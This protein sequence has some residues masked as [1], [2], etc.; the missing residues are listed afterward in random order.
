MRTFP[1]LG[2]Q[3]L[4]NLWRGTD[5][6][7][8]VVA[9]LLLMGIGYSL[10]RVLAGVIT[11][12]ALD[13]VEL[14]LSQDLLP[15]LQK[16]L[17]YEDL[18]VPMTGARLESFEQYV[19]ANIL[20][21]RTVRINI[22]STSGQVIY[23]DDHDLIGRTFD[24]ED[25]LREAI[26]GQVAK[27]LTPAE[28]QE[29][30]AEAGL[31]SMLEVY[32]PIVFEPPRVAGVFEVYEDYGPT[33]A[34]VARI[35]R[36][37]SVGLGLALAVSY[38]I[39]MPI[40]QRSM[41]VVRR[42]RDKMA[43]QATQLQEAY[44]ALATNEERFRSLVVN[45]SDVIMIVDPAGLVRYAS[46]SIRGT[47]GYEPGQ[48]EGRRLQALVRD[49]EGHGL[50]SILQ[51]AADDEGNCR[52]EEL[53][54]RRA[55]GEWCNVEA[56]V[57]SLLHNES[58]GGIVVNCRDVTERKRFELQL[59]EMAYHDGLTGLPNRVLFL[60]RLAASIS[61]RREGDI[62][63]VMIID[64]DHFKAVN[65]AL[66][67]AVGDELLVAVAR[68]IESVVPGCAARFGGDEFAV[69]LDGVVSPD[70]AA[71]TARRLLDGMREP[72][73]L[74]GHETF[75]T[76][77]IGV[78]VAVEDVEPHV[79]IRRADV[80][81]YHCKRMG[82]A[83]YA[84]ANADL[85]EAWM[86]RLSLETDLHHAL[87]RGEFSVQYQPVVDLAT[88]R[89]VGLE[90]LLRWHHSRR[91]DVPQVEFI[92]LAETT[93]QMVPMGRWALRTAC[94]EVGRWNSERGQGN[95]LSLAVNFSGIELM[96]PD[97]VQTVAETLDRSGLEARC[98]VID[99]TPS[100]LSGDAGAVARRLRE[101]SGLGIKV[102]LDDF[103][104]GYSALS[105]L[106]DLPASSLKIDRSFVADLA[107]SEQA[108]SIVR[109]IVQLGQSLGVD[110]V[111]VGV[112][113]AEQAD[114][115]SRMG[116]R[117]GQGYYFSGPLDGPVAEALLVDD[118]AL[119]RDAESFA[120]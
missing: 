72:F 77:S 65:D 45:G 60:R 43:R 98:L 48:I 95:L 1:R 107:G 120:A 37:T 33:A 24:L 68:Q 116:C 46:P 87:E 118:I 47:W 57:T 10:N 102:A 4:S 25:N 44:A 101:L 86:R 32:H 74:D 70:H 54:V 7:V 109:T 97:L 99:V 115:L 39:L 11:N 14:E 55:N 103:G 29:N 90:T 82:R 38:V 83:S 41:R 13:S 89:A 80:A 100:A 88:R 35:R 76:L 17:A 26:G 16:R 61:A 114:V 71:A 18:N 49:D 119:P 28:G 69:L 96:Q 42:Q 92:P 67:H 22:W 93:R 110:V 78:A 91:G 51:A 50:A 106:R 40:A 27:E 20:S 108:R 21:D 79:L 5:W 6:R 56:A 66:G 75:V 58:V 30:A 19:E 53:T 31:G 112:E 81:L 15:R 63:A 36:Y 2:S 94:E 113:T 104:R 73:V 85:D 52:K 59:A 64:V 3:R 62:V 9:L 111:A 12:N 34:Q 105:Y 117:F 84:M 23:S 8:A